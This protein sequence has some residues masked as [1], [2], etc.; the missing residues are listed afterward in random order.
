MSLKQQLQD[1]LKEAMRGGDAAR[2]DVLRLMMAAIKQAEVDGQKTLDDAGVQEVLTKQAK[3]RRESITDY[4]NAGRADL[5]AG[6]QAELTIIEVY[7]P[8]MMSEAEVRAVA[9]TLI[10]ELGVTDAKGMGQVMGRLM[11]QLK[12]KADGRLVNQV[13]RDLL[14]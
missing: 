7:L 9:A 1:D 12:G 2:R 10:A 8:Q 5:A 4:E 13:V 11:A 14:Q 3:Q 6:E